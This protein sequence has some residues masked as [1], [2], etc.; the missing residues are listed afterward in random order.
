MSEEKRSKSECI[1]CGLCNAYCPSYKATRN[2]V[3]SPRGRVKMMNNNSAD[4]SFYACTLCKAC[5]FNCP[6]NIDLD[7]KEVRVKLVKTEANEKMIENVRKYGNPFGEV[8]E[9]EVPDDLF[10][11]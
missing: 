10:C 8:E 6:L 1:N 3:F 4:E 7:F 5:E 2:E 11:C 9:G